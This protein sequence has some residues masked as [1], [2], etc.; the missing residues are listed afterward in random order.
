MTQHIKYIPA[1]ISDADPLTQ[2]AFHSKRYWDYPEEWIQLW[3]EDLTI[4]PEYISKNQ[5]IKIINEDILAGFYALEYKEKQLYIGY[6]W[7]LPEFI[8]KGLG[9]E[10]FTDLR[11]RCLAMNEP[12]VDVESDPNAEGFYIKMGA[13]KV[14]SISTRIEGRH[15]NVFRFRF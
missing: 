11:N 10:A 15:L 6:F 9:K 4:T 8:G 5:V 1:E 14:R 2:I 12:I 7:M 13:E 3:T